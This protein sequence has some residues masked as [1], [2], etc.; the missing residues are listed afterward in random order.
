MLGDGGAYDIPA[1]VGQNDHHV[2]QP[3]RRRRHDEHVDG[4]DTLGLIAQESPPGLIRW[5]SSPSHHVFGDRS[6][7]DLDAELEQLAMDPGRS[8]ERVGSAHLTN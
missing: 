2:E 5:C 1:I 8:P 3:K 7:T 4:R 6:L